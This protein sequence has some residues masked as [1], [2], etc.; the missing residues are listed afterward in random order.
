LIYFNYGPDITTPF[1][2]ETMKLAA[3]ILVSSV[4]VIW[5]NANQATC[6]DL[7]N[8]IEE[9]RDLIESSV[10]FVRTFHLR[11]WDFV[12]DKAR[13]RQDHEVRCDYGKDLG[14]FGCPNISGIQ[15]HLGACYPD[16]VDVIDTFFGVFDKKTTGFQVPFF[17]ASE[18]KLKYNELDQLGQRLAKHFKPDG[19]DPSQDKIAFFVHGYME[20]IDKS[21][22][23]E[24]KDAL[25]GHVKY[26]VMVDWRHGARR[27]DYAQA[28]V[29]TQLVGRQI[30]V[31]I[32]S[33]RKVLGLKPSNV[34]IIGHSLGAHT[35][36]L[37]GKWL[38][39]YFGYT[40]GKVTGLDPAGPLF[41]KGAG[42]IFEEA[43]RNM[44]LN[45][46]DADYV[47]AIH[48]N[49]FEG[50]DGS[51][52]WAA[53]NHFGMLQPVGH[54]DFYPSGGSHQPKCHLIEG[55]KPYCHHRA[56]VE[57]FIVSLKGGCPFKAYKCQDWN[58]FVKKECSDDEVAPMS[59]DVQHPKMGKF[60]LRMGEHYP[61][62]TEPDAV[63][64][65][66]EPENLV[67]SDL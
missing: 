11:M 39:E 13:L 12:K 24:L 6:F 64:L 31:A 19:F 49:G 61:Y 1:R 17:G 55:L 63:V 66:L 40:V 32:D 50:A 22:Y 60:Y 53:F 28:F 21:Y 35:A 57:Y 2:I 67:R 10:H 7:F 16:P 52:N 59:I 38:R 25:L 29:N 42:L 65:A 47:T 15:H 23:K 41:S 20:K 44:S 27:G 14:C 3:L 34:H 9:V 26:V 8:P 33:A 5:S 4:F 18:L 43:N 48:T 54:S 62:C 37:A 46:D 36:G 51:D 58:S 45:R 30:A 56:S